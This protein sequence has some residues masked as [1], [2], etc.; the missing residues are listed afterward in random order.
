MVQQ[1]GLTIRLVKKQFHDP[2]FGISLAA[3]K[4]CEFAI[5]YVNEEYRHEVRLAAK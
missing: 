1:D 3:V 5:N 4:E 2:K